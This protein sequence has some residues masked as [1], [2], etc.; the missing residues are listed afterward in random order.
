MIVEGR[1]NTGTE[2]DLAIIRGGANAIINETLGIGGS[3]GHDGLV[4]VTGA[5]SVLTVSEF[6][7]DQPAGR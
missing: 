6:C 7:A 2:N 4:L 5:G 3:A 1:V